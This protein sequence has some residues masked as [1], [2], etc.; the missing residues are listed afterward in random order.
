MLDAQE[1]DDVYTHLG[2]T[3]T[4]AGEARTPMVLARLVLLLM[5]EAGDAARVRRAIDA[6]AE[7]FGGA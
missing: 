2:H 5:Q 6:A 1:L 4:A 7:G 3:L